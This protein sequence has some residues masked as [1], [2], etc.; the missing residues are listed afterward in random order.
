MAAAGDLVRYVALG[1]ERTSLSLPTPSRPRNPRGYSKGKERR[2][3]TVPVTF[4]YSWKTGSSFWR[5]IVA[6]ESR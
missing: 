2:R 4:V 3:I 1:R 6:V 5:R